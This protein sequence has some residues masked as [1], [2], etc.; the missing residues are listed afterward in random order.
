MLKVNVS[1]VIT[2]TLKDDLFRNKLVRNGVIKVLGF[3]S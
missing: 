2:E 1:N 3:K